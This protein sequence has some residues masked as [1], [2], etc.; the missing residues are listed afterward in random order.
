MDELIKLVTQKAKIPE[1]QARQAVDAVLGFLKDK[2]PGPIASQVE[3]LL[4]GK[5]EGAKQAGGDIGADVL[6]GIGDLLGGKK[7]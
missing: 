3:G 4:G 1:A 2:L 7:K 5:K 6:G